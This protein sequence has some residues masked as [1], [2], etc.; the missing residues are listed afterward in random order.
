VDETL[1]D[2][3]EH[4]GIAA[5]KRWLTALT[6]AMEAEAVPG[7]TRRRIVNRVLFGDPDGDVFEKA[8]LE[9]EARLARMDPA[10][11]LGFRQ[12]EWSKRAESMRRALED[13]GRGLT[14]VLDAAGFENL[15]VRWDEHPEETDRG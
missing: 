7:D 3:A 4:S 14:R 5:A 6:E 11:V 8:S 2:A 1:K 15:E 10:R 12:D 13:T 9:V